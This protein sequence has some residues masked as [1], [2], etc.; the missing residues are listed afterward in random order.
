MWACFI[1]GVSLYVGVFGGPIEENITKMKNKIVS[2][3]YYF[4]LL[5][6]REHAHNL[7]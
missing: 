2:I 6:M 1:L 4:M 3:D 7:F 5:I